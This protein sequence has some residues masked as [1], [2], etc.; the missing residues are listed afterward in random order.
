M[1]NDIYIDPR[2]SVTSHSTVTTH[3]HRAPTDESVRLLK[4]LEAEAQK[5]IVESLRLT[6][7]EIDCVVHRMVDNFAVQTKYAI[8]MK[9]G[10][11]PVKVE[12]RLQPYDERDA[13]MEKIF[14]AV[15]E[16]IAVV[17]LENGFRGLLGK[18]SQFP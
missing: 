2:V 14:K 10:G 13:A 11:K 7:T 6:N 1:F 12:V 16:A 8:H 15:S 17:I 4:E 3:E 9:I 18:F 5:R